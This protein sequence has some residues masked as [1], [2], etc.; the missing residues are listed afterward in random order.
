AR[1]AALLGL[2]AA[3]IAGSVPRARADVSVDAD[4]SRRTVPVGEA[5][6]LVVTAHG[7]MGG[8]SEP[9]F[10]VP[11]NLDVLSN[12]RSQ[13]FSWVNGTSSSEVSFRYE[14]APRAPGTY[15]V[16]PIHV[17]VGGKVYIYPSFTLTAVSASGSGGSLAA[18]G[19]APARGNAPASLMVDVV[20]RDPRVGE[21]ALLRVRL[22]QRAPLAEDPRYSPPPTPGFWAERPSEPGS[23]YGESGGAR[24][25][26][27]E[28]RT[29]IYPLSA[30]IRGVREHGGRQPGNERH[31]PARPAIVPLDGAAA[32]AGD[33]LA[34]PAAVLVV[35]PA[36]EPVSRGGAGA[37]GARR[38]P[39]RGV[40][41]GPGRRSVSGAVRRPPRPVRA[42]RA[43]L[44]RRGG[45]SAGG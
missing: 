24:V 16:G 31:A 38:R 21:P 1:T 11:Q 36:R 33:D 19:T 3:A 17:K 20:P 15:T 22:V 7:A 26:V 41:S 28:T 12:G 43:T 45:G 34:R 39:L 8:V 10:A 9:D 4:I 18:P 2:L 42:A 27:T 14:L 44:A 40:A 37:G 6:T 29:R 5:A 25:L 32:L 30:G 23:Y 35:R 13:S